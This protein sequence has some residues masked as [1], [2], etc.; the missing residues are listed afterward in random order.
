MRDCL[1]LSL[2]GFDIA[3]GFGLMSVF[4]VFSFGIWNCLCVGVCFLECLWVS[5][6]IVMWFD[7]V[8]LICCLLA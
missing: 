5:R 8:D 6:F 4:W 3:A 2:G 1:L 7:L